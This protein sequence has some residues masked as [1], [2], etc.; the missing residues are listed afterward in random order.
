MKKRLILFVLLGMILSGCNGNNDDTPTTTTT[1]QSIVVERNELIGLPNNSYEVEFINNSG[2]QP[3][4]E[5]SDY[6]LIN[7]AVKSL[8]KIAINLLKEGE[9]YVKLGASQD[10]MHQI[11]V[12]AIDLKINNDVDHID[13]GE[14]LTIDLSH[15]V[16][17]TYSI[18]NEDI[19]TVN[20]DVIT[21]HKQGAFNLTVKYGEIVLS[22]AFDSYRRSNKITELS[23]NS[24]YV[25]YHGRNVHLGTHVIM[26]NTGSGFEVTFYG[27]ELYA[28][29]DGWYGSWYGETRL[30]VLVDGE[31]DTEERVV[32]LSQATTKAEYKL[33]DGLDEGVHTVKVLKITEAGASHMNL[34]ELRTDGYFKPTDKTQKLRMEVYGDSITAG[35]GNLRGDAADGTNATIQDGMQTYATYAASTLDADIN[36][37]AKSGIG[38]YTSANVDDSMQVNKLYR[39]VNYDGEYRW[40]FDNYIP[41]IVII[42]LGT[43]DHW[44]TSVF[45][46]EDFVAEYFYLVENLA[47]RYGEE[48]AFIFASGLMEQKVDSFVQKAVTSISSRYSNPIYTIQFDQ[49]GSGHPVKEEHKAASEKLVKLIK[50]NGLDV[51]HYEETEPEK[52]I[53]EI[54]GEQ[55]N[56]DLKINLQEDYPA[57][58]SIYLEGFEHD[59]CVYEEQYRNRFPH[60]PDTTLGMIEGDYEVRFYALVGDQKYYEIDQEPRILHIRKDTRVVELTVGTLYIPEDPNKDAATYGW[61]MSTILFEGSFTATSEKDVSLVNNN[62]MA[63][64]VTREAIY[65]D[66]YRV[67]THIQASNIDYTNSYIGLAPYYVDDLNYIWT[68]IG[69]NANGSL[70]T[71]GFTGAVNGKDIG[72]YDCWSFANLKPDFN[73]GVDI[74]VVR[75]GTELTVEFMG[76]KETQTLYCLNKDTVRIGVQSSIE[77]QVNYTNFTQTYVEPT[78]EKSVW[79]QSACLYA[80]SY[81]V[82]SDDS[83]S[84]SNYNNW[85][86]GFILKVNPYADNY[87]VSALVKADQDNYNGGTDTQIAIV[88]FFQD[89]NNFVCV[90]LQWQAGNTLKSIGMTGKIGGVDLGWNDFWNFASVPTSLLEGNVLTVARSGNK[91]T[92]TFGGVTETK[93][94][95]KLGDL[96]C[97]AAGVWCH[98]A[99]ATFENYKVVA[100]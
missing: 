33:V 14:T 42:N 94:L 74:A 1:G 86:A 25:K 63:G 73:A 23:R 54:T 36:V 72:F 11:N 56:F 66:D 46:E 90:Y 48:T 47:K 71:I 69:F 91:I 57:Y 38:L 78:G 15:D 49:C 21:V 62:W 85:M 80:Q 45:D 43:N 10:N 8:N 32:I 75:H 34:Y 5:V 55:A 98:N 35:Y 67:S 41:D 60:N 59:K 9:G 12:K 20:G 89:A 70:R 37:Q 95:S 7:V 6:E 27:K 93:T 18:D 58:V 92:T 84:I 3:F 87:E 19:A 44:N 97:Y 17:A 51:I 39:Y 65:G 2:T 79:S 4:I 88:P 83:V 29:M 40:N 16:D 13:V 99:N 24:I 82:I 76:V 30:T 77:T 81:E 52:E 61:N 50:D 22:K 100:K 68:Y 96:S 31:T 64:F 26:N 53:S 28:T